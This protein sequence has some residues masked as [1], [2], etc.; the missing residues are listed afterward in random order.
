M[1]LS[2]VIVVEEDE[3]AKGILEVHEAFERRERLVSNKILTPERARAH[4]LVGERKREV[5]ARPQLKI[6]AVW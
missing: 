6:R 5:E 2:K 3:K 4:G 1:E